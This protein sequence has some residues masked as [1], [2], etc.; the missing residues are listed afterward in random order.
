MVRHLLHKAAAATD[1]AL[2][3]LTQLDQQIAAQLRTWL[4]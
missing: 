1:R 2:T 3:A 4:H